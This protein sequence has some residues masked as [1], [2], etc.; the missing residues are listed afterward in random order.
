V[1]K[2]LFR[3]VIV[4]WVVFGL[5]FTIAAL[6]AHAEGGV[7]IIQPGDMV[8]VKLS[9][10]TDAGEDEIMLIEFDERGRGAIVSQFDKNRIVAIV[11]PGDDLDGLEFHHFKTVSNFFK[12]TDFDKLMRDIDDGKI[13]VWDKVKSY[14]KQGGAFALDKGKDFIQWMDETAEKMADYAIDKG[15]G[16][17]LRNLFGK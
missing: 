5:A 8:F 7:T 2:F 1:K 4:V 14:S 12:R 3:L 10:K 9:T 17:K 16:D 15:W 13:S 11:R 6:N